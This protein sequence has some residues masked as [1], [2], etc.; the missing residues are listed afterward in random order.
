[1]T[2]T[3]LRLRL[4]LII[5]LPL[6]AIG[7]AVGAWQVSDA[8][9]KAA[10]L[11]DRSLLSAAL[12]ISADVALSNGD[13][14]S[15]ET[16]DLLQDTSGGPVFY[17]VYA[18]DGIYVLGYATPPVSLDA[19]IGSEEEV[20]F[21][22]GRYHRRDVRV[23]RYRSVT[24]IDGINGAFT[25][26]VWQDV[27]VRR[28]FV[29]DLVLRTFTVIAVLIGSVAL[30]VWFGVGLGLR[31][32]LD[33]EDA[34]SRRSSDD[35]SPIR[36][37]VPPETRGLVTRLN[38]L[39]GQVERTMEAQTALISNAAHQ[40]RNPIAGVLA[41]AE[42]VQTAP[43]QVAMQDRTEELLHA[44]RRASDLANKLLTLERVRAAPEGAFDSTLEMGAMINDIV[45]GFQPKAA[46]RG[47]RIT[48]DLA[49]GQTNVVAD[50]VMVEEAITNLIDNAL[51]HG[52]AALS[53]VQV[54][55]MRGGNNAVVSVVDDGVGLDPADIETVLSRFGQASPGEGSGLGLSIAE[56]VAERHGGALHLDTDQRGLA[57]TLRLPLAAISG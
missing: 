7:A 29:Q 5:L 55:L 23:L 14:I 25:Y 50:A 51:Q 19:P 27:A 2:S 48:A 34:I 16:T 12:A 9:T 24:T 3:S 53:Q 39:F 33:L 52:G 36:R 56:A 13:A 10:D 44:A 37:A 47:V 45:E 8:R 41:M 20:T 42:A 35:L 28:A 11:F 46:A 43:T 6:L 38:T 18:P 32:L 40:L 17:H 4:T 54:N 21:F 57:V 22:D 49:P 1:M 30:V 15:L 26:T 31:P